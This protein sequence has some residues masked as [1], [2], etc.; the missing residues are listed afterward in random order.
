VAQRTFKPA[1]YLS[2]ELTGL[3]YFPAFTEVRLSL[4][5]VDPGKAALGYSLMID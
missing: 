3:K 1:D 5:I 2:G 4:E